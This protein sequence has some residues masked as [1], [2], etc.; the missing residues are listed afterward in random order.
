MTR[1]LNHLSN[2]YPGGETNKG[3]RSV[4]SKDDDT[5]P[6]R[7]RVW[8][9]PRSARRA[10]SGG[11]VVLV[12][13]L[14]AVPL[15]GQGRPSGDRGSAPIRISGGKVRIGSQPAG[16]L[17]SFSDRGGL[18]RVIGGQ[19]ERTGDPR[20][21]RFG[22][23]PRDGGRSGR[24]ARPLRGGYY[25]PYG[26]YYRN[27][28]YRGSAEG[29]L[30]YDPRYLI[31]EPAREAPRLGRAYNLQGPASYTPIR[32]HDEGLVRGGFRLRPVFLPTL[33]VYAAYPVW[34]GSLFDGRRPG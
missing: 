18:A 25:D 2:G 22:P 31:R 1:R 32:L 10:L 27:F 16:S 17:R 11:G 8:L 6:L 19:L 29:A 12:A 20:A 30:A 23:A 4:R 28:G 14:S 5:R 15:S 3:A 9:G 33:V 21:N 34:R 13:L 24:R 26:Y 7:S